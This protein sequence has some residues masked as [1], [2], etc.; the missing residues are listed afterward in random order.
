MERLNG[1]LWNAISLSL[2]SR[3]LDIRHWET[4]L[5]D[6]LHAIRSLLCTSTNETPHERIFKYNRKS[7]SGT[8][9]PSWLTQPGPVLLNRNPRVSKYD[10]LTEEVELVD[11]NPQYARIRLSN[12]RETNV[13]LRDLAPQVHIDSHTLPIEPNPEDPQETIATPSP[14]T[15]NAHDPSLSSPESSTYND[16]VNKPQ[17]VSSYNL[18]SREI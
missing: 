17:R 1:T 3:N 15:P 7:T 13:S 6:A 9:L 2:K 4:V 12:G 16:L 11:C 10:S 14:H 18:R 8:S 5:P